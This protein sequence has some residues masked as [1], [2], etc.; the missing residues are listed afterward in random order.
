ME[1]KL[2]FDALEEIIRVRC[3]SSELLEEIVGSIRGYVVLNRR[4]IARVTGG[5]SLYFG[6]GIRSRARLLRRFVAH[7]RVK[8]VAA[9]NRSNGDILYMDFGSNSLL[10]LEW[11]NGLGPIV[12]HVARIKGGS[13]GCQERIGSIWLGPSG[14]GSSRFAL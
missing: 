4:P 3:S 10:T 1:A 9:K 11:Q 5:S 6:G 12:I 14:L 7:C 13:F 8:C 2:P